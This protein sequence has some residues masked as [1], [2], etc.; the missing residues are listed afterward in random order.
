MTKIKQI[1]I[2]RTV[3]YDE[4]NFKTFAKSNGLETSD[5]NYIAWVESC[6]EDFEDP[7][8]FTSEN[9]LIFKDA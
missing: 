8:T 2:T 9:Q 4:E 3:I 5:D 7:R 1:V 6:H